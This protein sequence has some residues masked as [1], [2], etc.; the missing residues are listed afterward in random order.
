MDQVDY[1]AAAE[2]AK[3]TMRGIR[4]QQIGDMT[5]DEKGHGCDLVVQYT[6]AAKFEDGVETLSLS[7]RF[8][9]M[10]EAQHAR[11]ILRYG[12]ADLGADPVRRNPSFRD[13]AFLVNL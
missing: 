11:E 13:P 6:K 7:I 3:I 9:N 4:S 10:A 12:S 5:F 1:Q 2:L 8:K